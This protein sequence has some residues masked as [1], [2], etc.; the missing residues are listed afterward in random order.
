MNELV[1]KLKQAIVDSELVEL[2]I[3]TN[4]LEVEWFDEQM[5]HVLEK[6]LDEVKGKTCYEGL[7][8]DPEP[9]DNC[10]VRDAIAASQECGRYSESEK[11]HSIVVAL[12][13]GDTHVAEL[14]IRIPKDVGGKPAGEEAQ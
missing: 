4:D 7:A 12:P 14:V 9:H 6:S 13:L 1:E 10:T 3:L 8:G 11:N 5:A 2:M